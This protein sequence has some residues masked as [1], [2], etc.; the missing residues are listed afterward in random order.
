VGGGWGYLNFFPDCHFITESWD[1]LWSHPNP[2]LIGGTAGLIFPVL[3]LINKTWSCSGL[4]QIYQ[5]FK[6]GRYNNAPLLR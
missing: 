5:D 3:V 4:L 1:L 6:K 2:D